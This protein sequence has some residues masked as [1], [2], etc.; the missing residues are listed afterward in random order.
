MNPTNVRRPAPA[1]NEIFST[2][3]GKLALSPGVPSLRG[4]TLPLLGI[5]HVQ[6]VRHA[7]F[8]RVDDDCA[9]TM[10]HFAKGAR[11]SNDARLAGSEHDESCGTSSSCGLKRTIPVDANKLRSKNFNPWTLSSCECSNACVDV[12]NGKDFRT[13]ELGLGAAGSCGNRLK[14]DDG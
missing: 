2:P 9:A 3:A 12:D 5:G 6:D 4:S 14:G 10:R 11:P 8:R 7:A 13:L 1:S